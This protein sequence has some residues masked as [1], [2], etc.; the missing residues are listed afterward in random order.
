M[1]DV[2]YENNTIKIIDMIKAAAVAFLYEAAGDVK[3]DA[4]RGTRV[5]T[6]QTKSAWAYTVDEAETE[7]VV[8]NPLENAIWE[9]FGTGEYAVKGDGRKGGWTYQDEVGN[10]HRTNGKKPTRALET[11]FNNNKPNFPKMLAEKLGKV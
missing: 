11:A 9:E 7:A 5:D 4:A 10:W 6:G 2:Q 1:A 3:S 8:G